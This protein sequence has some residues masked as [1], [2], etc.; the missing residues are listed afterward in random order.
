MIAGQ[1]A[2]SKNDSTHLSY[3]ILPPILFCLAI[4]AI[5]F[6]HAN[7]AD[8][9]R[10]AGDEMAAE[11]FDIQAFKSALHTLVFERVT[12]IGAV[13][14]SNRHVGPVGC[15][16]RCNGSSKSRRETLL[17]ARAHDGACVFDLIDPRGKIHR[18]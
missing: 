7:R 16:R 5:E 4:L 2:G 10:R 9:M 17:I 12:L 18:A 1:N 14:I 3:V 6:L 15:R 11:I 13:A 8:D